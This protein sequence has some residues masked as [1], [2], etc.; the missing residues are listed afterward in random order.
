[1]EPAIVTSSS[2]NAAGA[3]VLRLTLADDGHAALPAVV[4]MEPLAPK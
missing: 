1:V 2:G 3:R 4:Q